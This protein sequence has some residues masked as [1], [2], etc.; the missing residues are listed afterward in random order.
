M[1]D[2]I[3][4]DIRGVFVKPKKVYYLG[5]LSYGTPYFYPR[6]FNPTI[7]SIRKVK[8][9]YNRNKNFDLFGYNI[10]IG[11]PIWITKDEIGWKDKFH[12]PRFEWSP[13]FKLFIFKWQFCIF[14]NAPDNNED[15]YYEM[16][17]WYSYYSEKDIEV[18][19]KTW[20]WRDGKTKEST[21]NSK[22]L[23]KLDDSKDI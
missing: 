22:Y 14:W 10:S 19:E 23:I 16:A 18:A 11:S 7:L 20:P 12:S 5:K 21:W 17:L 6:K 15:L 4:K 13:S 9:K 8:P 1:K 2:N 3:L